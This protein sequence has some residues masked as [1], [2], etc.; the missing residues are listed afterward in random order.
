MPA[1]VL[2]QEYVAS[3]GWPWTSQTPS[4]TG[5]VSPAASV[6]VTEVF[7]LIAPV[8][9]RSAGDSGSG[10]GADLA[11]EG[12]R[13]A[14][15]FV[16]LD[17]AP[18]D[19]QQVEALERE[20]VARGIHPGEAAGT[21]ERSARAPLH[22]AAV[23]LGGRGEDLHPQIGHRLGEFADERLDPVGCRELKA[24]VDVLDSA[25]C[26]HGDRGGHVTCAD[27]LEITARNRLG[28][29]R[30]ARLLNPWIPGA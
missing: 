26:P 25:G 29:F 3:P 22:R 15:R 21:G 4:A 23:A 28:T 16:A 1:G 19:G 5:W 13:V 17:Q 18:G 30:H 6:P 7:R 24:A 9:R 20:A 10:S 8:S 27:R 11:Q 2:D 14:E 12:G